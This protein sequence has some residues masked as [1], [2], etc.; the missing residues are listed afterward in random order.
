MNEKS[1][2]V[3]WKQL[4]RNGYM[5]AVLS[6]LKYEVNISLYHPIILLV[7]IILV[8]SLIVIVV[9]VI[10]SIVTVIVINFECVV[11]QKA[12]RHWVKKQNFPSK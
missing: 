2:F 5:P 10:F 8:V 1:F 4:E 6:S 3:S 9:V 11:L 7:S 12:P